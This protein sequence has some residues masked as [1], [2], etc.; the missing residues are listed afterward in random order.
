MKQALGPSSAPAHAWSVEAYGD[1]VADGAF[2]GACTDVQILPA[3][4]SIAQ[5][6][7]V[8]DQ[9]LEDSVDAL[10]LPLVVR[11]RLW[12][13]SID[14]A[15]GFD[16]GK[17]SPLSQPSRLLA[18]P[19]TQLFGALGVDALARGPELLDDVVPVQTHLGVRE[20]DLLKTPDMLTAISKEHRLLLAVATLE[21]LAV[22]PHEERFVALEGRDE[23]LV[24]GPLDALGSAAQSVDDANDGQF[25]VLALVAFRAPL[26][27]MLMP[28]KA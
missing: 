1:E 13:R 14:V 19:S 4:I 12:N 22:Q 11:T 16:D 6:A 21:R 7:L 28:A 3:Q 5:A 18:D 9:V 27:R 24:D 2:G 10:A 15:Q 17:D 20:V 8:F 26:A 25:G 23:P